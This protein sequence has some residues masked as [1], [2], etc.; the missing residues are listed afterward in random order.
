MLEFT[1]EYVAIP[2]H[3]Q[4][5]MESYVERKLY[6]GSFLT[7]VLSNNLVNAVSK[8]D[9]SNLAALPLIVKFM[10]NRM[11]AACWGSEEKIHNWCEDSFYHRVCDFQGTEDGV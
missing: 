5:A 4:S 2:G 9:S 11:P 10:Y 1:D 3:T 7:A 8:A 6:P